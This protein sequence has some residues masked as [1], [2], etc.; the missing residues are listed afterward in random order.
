MNKYEQGKMYKIVNDINNDIYVGST[1]VTLVKRMYK[2]RDRILERPHYPLSILMN[3]HGK[4][5]F[6]IELIENWPCKNQSELHERER[7]WMDQLQP[8]LNRNKPLTPYERKHYTRTRR[9]QSEKYKAWEKAYY[10]TLKGKAARKR[11]YNNRKLRKQL[12]QME[13]IIKR[14][15]SVKPIEIQEFKLC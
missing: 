13:S 14:Y 1:C 9:S 4:K 15:K 3:T 10:Q 6:R 7:Y 12:D 5:H 11:E 2:H 8:S